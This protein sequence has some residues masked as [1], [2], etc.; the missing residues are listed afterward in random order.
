ML[1]IT[2]LH[3]ALALAATDYNKLVLEAVSSMPSGGGYSRNQTADDAIPSMVSLSEGNILVTPRNPTFCT[4][5][6]YM[7][8]LK[9]VAE[10][11]KQGLGLSDEM[12]SALLIRGQ[13][14]GTEAWGRWN[15]NGPGTAKLFSELNLGQSFFGFKKAK[16]GD[17]LKIF[18]NGEI[19]KKER[20]HSVIYLGQ[21]F[22]KG[23]LWVRIFSSN[24]PEGLSEKWILKSRIKLALFS[25]LENPEG[26]K[27]ILSLPQTDA[28]LASMLEAESS[29]SEVLL[30]LQ[31]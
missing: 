18:F 19:G 4:G 7:V 23:E 28:F 11:Q 22:R 15:S 9:V 17:F 20:G 29:V 14:D 2:I 5:A 30:Q 26:L 3:S 27:N 24:T 8:F 13:R 21:E 16:P 6:T 10:L 25:R 12:L 31:K 1:W